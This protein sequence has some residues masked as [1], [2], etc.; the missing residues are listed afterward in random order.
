MITM[1]NEQLDRV[2]ALLCS[3]KNGSRTV[4]YNSINRSVSAIQ[5]EASRQICDKYNISKADIRANQNIRVRKA[6]KN[7]LASEISYNTFK[8]PLIRF[9]VSD[10]TPNSR[11]PLRV[12]VLKGA[13]GG[14]IENAFVAKMTNGHIGMFERIQGRQMDTRHSKNGNINKHTQAIGAGV[15]DQFYGPSVSQMIESG[16]IRSSIEQRGQEVFNNRVN[17]E[18]NRIINGWG[19]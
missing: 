15:S 9:G 14:I 13:S 3:V 11:K 4:F 8:I 12:T 1:S 18:I 6:T 5:T 10:K 19:N 2:E 7:E 16:G 17:H